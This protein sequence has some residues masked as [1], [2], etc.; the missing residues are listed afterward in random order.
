MPTVGSARAARGT[1]S[2]GAGI[3]G[4]APEVGDRFGFA[5]AAA[6][7]DCDDYTDLVVGT[8]YEDIGGQADSGYVQIIWGSADGL[9][10]GVASRQITQTNFPNADI[11]A[12]DQFGYAV[13]A[14]EDVGQGG[15]PAPDAYAVAIGVPGGDIGGAERRRLGRGR[16][17]PSMASNVE[18]THQPELDRGPGR[19]RGRATGSAPRSRSTISCRS[20]DNAATFD[21]RRR[22]LPERRHRLPGRRGDGDHRP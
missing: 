4:G 14:L 16:C 11:T 9:G 3:V 18:T 2:Q 12:G 21:R 8:P 7:F 6:D 20:G 1:V 22:R 19:R 5:L 17:T 10:S 13:D 15:T